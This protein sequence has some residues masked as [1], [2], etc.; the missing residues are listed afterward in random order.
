MNSYLA[1]DKIPYWLKVIGKSKSITIWMQI[2]KKK[3]IP[4]R[5]RRKNNIEPSIVSIHVWHDRFSV[6]I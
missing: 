4:I 6:K 2:K 3:K 5:S 1:V